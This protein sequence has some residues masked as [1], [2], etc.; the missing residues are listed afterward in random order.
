MPDPTKDWQVRQRLLKKNPDLLNLHIELV[1]TGQISEEEFW[2]G[3]EYLLLAEAVASSQKAGRNAQIVDPK[4]EQTESGDIKIKLSQQL[5]KDIFEQY[6]IVAKVYND[7]V[8]DPLEE[9]EFWHR[10]FHSKLFDR[11]RTTGRSSLT[12]GAGGSIKD[13]AIFDK[14][15]EDEDDDL[16]P[17]NLP[18][19]DDVYRLL[20]LAATEEDHGETGNAKDFTMRAGSQKKSLPLMR[21]F[22]EHS[23]RLLTQA[24]GGQDP[25]NANLG[26]LHGGDAGSRKYYED[27]VLEDLQGGKAD[28]FLPLDV[29]DRENAY[30]G[31]GTSAGGDEG[32]GAG[33]AGK[34]RRL[35]DDEAAEVFEDSKRRMTS[36]YPELGKFHFSRSHAQR[37]LTAL[38]ANIATR[39]SNASSSSTSHSKAFPEQILR[40]MLSCQASANEFLRHFWSAILPSN[41]A[42]FGYSASSMASPAQKAGKAIRMIEYLEKTQERV[43]TIVNQAKTVPGADPIG[44]KEALEPCLG[45]VRKAIAFYRAR[46]GK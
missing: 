38:Q 36:W 17:K 40:S 23:E 1:R 32:D 34:K 45:A 14:Y 5:I 43:D 27:I 21:R 22:N 37:A 13:D 33:A 15:L 44:V 4:P 8:P 7:N 25:K 46:M 11:H 35:T 24:L 16:E 18:K 9:A 39:M 19:Y 2:E 10:Y 6:P 42:D 30:E 26:H 28:E 12:A 31:M 41:P 29:R 20:D 3:R